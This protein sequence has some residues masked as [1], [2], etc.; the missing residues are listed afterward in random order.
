MD[1]SDDEYTPDQT[2]NNH[3]SHQSSSS[4]SSTSNATERNVRIRTNNY[5]N[6]NNNNAA[7][8][9]P[10]AF[11]PVEVLQPVPLSYNPITLLELESEDARRRR[12][13]LYLQ[14]LRVVAGVGKNGNTGSSAYSYYN[15]KRNQQSASKGGNY[16]RLLLFREANSATGKVVYIIE[17]ASE[18]QRL[19]NK[20]SICRDNGTMRVGSY[21]AILNPSPIKTYLANDIPIVS[22]TGSGIYL[23]TPTIVD[24]VVPRPDISQNLTSAFV[25]NN[26]Q[27]EVLC[28]EPVNTCCTGLFCDRQ[29]LPEVKSSSKGCG[30]YNGQTRQSGI[31]ISHAIKIKYPG[32]GDNFCTIEQFSSVA[33]SRIYLAGTGTFPSSVRLNVLDHTPQFEHLE[34]TI[35]NQIDYVNSHFGFTVIGWYKKGTINDH[36]VGDGD[37]D[38]IQVESGEIGYNVVSIAPTDLTIQ[39]QATFN[40]NKFDVA[41]LNQVGES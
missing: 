31:I 29:R 37:N 16:T 39:E 11:L 35:D 10:R 34:D 27:L 33:F 8:H 14:L 28:S 22:A 12:T 26:M 6:N 9:L 19:W 5:N 4:S 7:D 20:N 18:N 17:T 3:T 2:N 21:F 40:E 13:V 24:Q 30:C 36:V 1:S 38:N 25:L 23:K 15:K 32:N 41:Q